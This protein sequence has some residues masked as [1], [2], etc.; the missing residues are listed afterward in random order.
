MTGNSKTDFCFLHR[1]ASL[2]FKGELY[3]YEE[4]RKLTDSLKRKIQCEVT[5]GTQMVAIALH[6]DVSFVVSM[7]ALLELK[8]A[9]IPIDIQQPFERIKK[10]LDST[11]VSDVITTS[12]VA[13]YFDNL[14]NCIYLDKEKLATKNSGKELGKSDN[15]YIL[16]T[17][18]S[19]GFPKGAVIKRSGLINFIKGTIEKIDFAP[20]KVIGSFT[21]VCF[22]IFILETILSLSQGLRV[23]LATESER[24]NPKRIIAMIEEYS[25][26]M[27][28]FTPSSM[29]MLH[30][31]DTKF[32]CLRNVSEIMIGGEKFPPRLLEDLQKAMNGKIYNMYGPVETTVWTTIADL[33]KS[34]AIHIGEPIS[35]TEVMVLNAEYEP[36]LPGEEG[37][38]C[39]AGE[40]LAEGY[41]KEKD[42]TEK[43]FITRNGQRIYCT[44]DIGKYN[45]DGQLECLGRKDF[46][47][48]IHG[49]RVELEDVE[50]NLMQFDKV[51]QVATCFVENN[52][53]QFLVAF[54]TSKYAI[55]GDE[56][57]CYATK[58]L[59][60]YMVPRFFIRASQMY[61]TSSMK[62][63]R[64]K[65]LQQ[66]WRP[67]IF[68]KRELPK[69]KTGE[70]DIYLGILLKLIREVLEEKTQLDFDVNLDKDVFLRDTP[71][72]SLDYVKLIVRIE[73]NFDV[74]FS[75]DFMADYDKMKIGDILDTI[76]NEK[77]IVPE[78]REVECYR[79]NEK[80]IS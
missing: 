36:T 29:Q 58:V 18:G 61:Y 55:S 53:A 8:I 7:L 35:N 43:S 24:V 75:D 69:D 74:E 27:L 3:E 39:I 49:N 21:N 30:M 47:I 65:L 25:I 2:L 23:V 1:D 9:F 31:Y 68:L 71:L 13:S 38:I 37:E 72:D 42:L 70:E 50:A 26:Q 12:D 45:E 40:G 28:Q 77:I 66:Y 34:Q 76:K 6:R 20:T 62:K 15:A 44:G 10:I 79:E 14:T 54:Y 57:T 11:E 33:T 41:Y 78:Y 46:Q 67:E 73:S 48:K 56:W 52:N 51:E 60:E 16:F 4:L 22:D 32:R 5:E 19:T 80:I 17:S 59:P 64:K 63:D